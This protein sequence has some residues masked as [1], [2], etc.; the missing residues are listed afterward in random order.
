MPDKVWRYQTKYPK[1]T[2]YGASEHLQHRIIWCY[3]RDIITNTREITARCT[4]KGWK[5]GP[6][7]NYPKRL[8]EG[9]HTRHVTE[10]VEAH[11]EQIG[12][13]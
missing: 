8:I 7:G 5:Y 3:R 6:F 11:G 13:F 2:S 9:E 1:S 12:L 4:C 10:T